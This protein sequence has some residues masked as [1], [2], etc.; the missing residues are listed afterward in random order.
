MNF[1]YCDH[2]WIRL[3]EQDIKE[4]IKNSKSVKFNNEKFINAID[5]CY[6]VPFI[7]IRN[8]SHSPECDILT[9]YTDCFCI[10]CGATPIQ[11]INQSFV[12]DLNGRYEGVCDSCIDKFNIK[13]FVGNE[14]IVKLIKVLGENNA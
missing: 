11:G 3:T 1:K 4:L 6:E 12:R 2:W 8:G 10:V 13:P 9:H 14:T 5:G 7:R